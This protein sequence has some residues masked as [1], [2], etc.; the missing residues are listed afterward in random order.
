MQEV[1]RVVRRRHAARAFTGLGALKAGGRWNS[2]GRCVVYCADHPATALL[3]VVV[4]LEAEDFD[5]GDFLLFRAGLPE[6]EMEMLSVA[7]LPED[8]HEEAMGV[9]TQ[10][11]GDAWLRRGEKLALAVP[12]ALVPAPAFNVLLN[13]SHRAYLDL[14]VS[15]PEPLRV[16]GRLVRGSTRNAIRNAG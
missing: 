8:W 13:P 9:A 3:E 14:Q 7:M 12:S 11:L 4:H 6:E 5:P 2:K 16:D 10:G 1:W 15:E